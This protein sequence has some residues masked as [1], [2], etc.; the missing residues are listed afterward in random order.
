LGVHEENGAVVGFQAGEDATSHGF[1]EWIDLDLQ[2][3]LAGH[4]E[5]RGQLEDAG[6]QRILVRACFE[7][8]LGER[9]DVPLTQKHVEAEED[10]E[11]A[12]PGRDRTATLRGGKQGY[13]K[14]HEPGEIQRD[15]GGGERDQEKPGEHPHPYVLAVELAELAI[16]GLVKAVHREASAP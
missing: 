4:V 9:A 3:R 12:E 11:A 14:P 1:E 16:Q 13:G 10:G 2:M 6:P 8:L 7:E 5:E 15:D